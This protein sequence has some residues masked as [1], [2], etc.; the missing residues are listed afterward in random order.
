MSLVLEMR[1]L[2]AFVFQTRE[3]TLHMVADSHCSLGPHAF[4]LLVDSGFSELRT[5]TISPFPT[6]Q[7]DKEA[8]KQLVQGNCTVLGTLESDDVDSFQVQ[9]KAGERISAEA[10]GVRLGAS[11]LDTT[12]TLRD[13][14]GRILK[15]VDDTPMLNQDPAFSILAPEDSYVF[16]ICMRWKRKSNGLHTSAESFRLHPASME[17]WLRVDATAGF[18]SGQQRTQRLYGSRR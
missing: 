7:E 1:C 10:V 11:L 17:A 9:A 18:E 6:V 5:L 12:L 15:R 14:S 2:R 3:A 13:P 16:G 4:R 8:E